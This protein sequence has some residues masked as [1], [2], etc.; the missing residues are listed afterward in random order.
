MS[1]DRVSHDGMLALA[2]LLAKLLLEYRV[3]FCRSASK[4]KGL[5]NELQFIQTQF[6]D[7]LYPDVRGEPKD[8]D[9]WEYES[10]LSHWP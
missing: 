5:R 3:S 10:L 8:Y 6:I 9:V 4:K 1:C 2:E 7:T